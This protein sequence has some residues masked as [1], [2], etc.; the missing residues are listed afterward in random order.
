MV[1]ITKADNRHRTH[2]A[3]DMEPIGPRIMRFVEHLGQIGVFSN[4]AIIWPMIFV[5]SGEKEAGV[6]N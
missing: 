3:I 2:S 4:W 6:S 1:L 5:S